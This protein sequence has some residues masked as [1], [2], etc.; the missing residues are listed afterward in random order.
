MYARLRHAVAEQSDYHRNAERKQGTDKALAPFMLRSLSLYPRI[1]P[2]FLH[3]E[4]SHS[5]PR[6]QRILMGVCEDFYSFPP[7]RAQLPQTVESV[8]ISA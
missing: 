1:L 8:P 3:I 2:S 7:N 4:A 5:V 6:P